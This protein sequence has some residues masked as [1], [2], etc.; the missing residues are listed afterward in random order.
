VEVG[1]PE[2]GGD[3]CLGWGLE[4]IVI[5]FEGKEEEGVS[6][7]GR[8]VDLHCAHFSFF[9]ILFWEALLIEK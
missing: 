8:P 6:I 3:G 4:V 7:L 5:L 2:D 1:D 9:S